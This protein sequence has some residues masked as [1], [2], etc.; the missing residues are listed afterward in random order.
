MDYVITECAIKQSSVKGTLKVP[1][2]V[3]LKRDLGMEDVLIKIEITARW[4]GDTEDD[5]QFTSRP[6]GY[7]N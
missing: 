1:Y 5:E 6:V 4:D 2:N 7:T 3:V